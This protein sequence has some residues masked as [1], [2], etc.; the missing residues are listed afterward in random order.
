MLVAI[1]GGNNMKEVDFKIQVLTPLFI[2]GA[3]PRGADLRKEGIRAPSLR[4]A[5]R[6][7]FRAMMG[8]V[9][10]SYYE[11]VRVMEDEIFGTTENASKVVIRSRTHSPYIART[12]K[13]LSG[14]EEGTLYLGL[15]LIEMNWRTREVS[16]VK[17]CF[18][19]SHDKTEPDFEI[20]LTFRQDDELI[21]KLV[22]GAMWL[23]INFGGLGSRIR[24]GFGT[25]RVLNVSGLS[26]KVSFKYDGS[27]ASFI[28]YLQENLKIIAEDYINFAKRF[29][30]K[31]QIHDIFS[32]SDELP[33]FSCFG[34]WK[35]LVFQNKGWD[36]WESVMNDF[37][38]FFQKFRK[39]PRGK[40][41]YGSTYD[42]KFIGPFF[43]NKDWVRQQQPLDFKNDIFGLPIQYRSA[44]RSEGRDKQVRARLSAKIVKGNKEKSIDRRSSP[45]FFRPVKFAKNSYGAILLLFE[46]KFLPDGAEE[47]LAPIKEKWPEDRELP[48]QVKVKV[49]DFT[50]IEKFLNESKSRFTLVGMLPEKE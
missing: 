27:K 3:D 10:G 1:I 28:E 23:L 39:D 8:G 48:E 16:L 31:I 50:D 49:A 25:I 38:A 15:N 35:L 6:F 41:R 9:I 47:V 24:R 26:S 17:N 11:N 2:A 34:N 42:Y 18:M 43:D 19:P 29:N 22:E 32:P 30:D 14:I 21:R 13:R 40:G 33:Y 36:S 12:N 4:G 5:L 44:T 7:W 46:S 20:I 45:L 37:G